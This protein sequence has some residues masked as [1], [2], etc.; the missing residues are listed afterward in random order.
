MITTDFPTD[1][2]KEMLVSVI[3]HTPHNTRVPI[4]DEDE[5]V[6]EDNFF[7]DDDDNND[8]YLARDRIKSIFAEITGKPITTKSMRHSAK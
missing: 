7:E 8:Q 1:E 6:L 4:I 5:L 3:A 2:T